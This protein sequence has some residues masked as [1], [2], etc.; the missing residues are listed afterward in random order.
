M[1]EY[2]P[3][4]WIC[5]PLLDEKKNRL[6]FRFFYNMFDQKKCINIPKIYITLDWT[7]RLISKR[8]RLKEFAEIPE[9]PFEM[10]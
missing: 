8:L 7:A 9:N 6:R 1:S 3:I 2:V 5:V 10:G 4:I